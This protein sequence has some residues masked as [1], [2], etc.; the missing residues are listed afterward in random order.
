M[1]SVFVI[2]QNLPKELSTKEMVVSKPSF[3]EEVKASV[4][5]KGSNATIGPNYLRAIAE[6]IG[7]RYDRTFNPFRN[8]V[9]QDYMG[10]I[11]ESD[12]A[13]AE[14]VH[15]MFQARYPVIYQRYYESKVRARSFFTRVIYFTGDPADAVFFARLG[16]PEIKEEEVHAHLGQPVPVVAPTIVNA[17][18]ELT[19][20]EALQELA[21]ISQAIEAEAPP[22]QAPAAKNLQRQSAL[23]KPKVEAATTTPVEKQA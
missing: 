7:R 14:I 9:P 16:I 20:S 12:E 3:V 10:R 6:E 21:D 19:T 8:I 13:V 11:C 23:K 22:A 15:E 1:D 5:R 2:T 18:A 4:K 17:P